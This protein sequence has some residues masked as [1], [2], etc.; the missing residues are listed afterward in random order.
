MII[1]EMNSSCCLSFAPA[2]APVF[3]EW[4]PAN[5]ALVD[6]DECRKI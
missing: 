3:A 1:I 6:H 2:L 5:D 4:K